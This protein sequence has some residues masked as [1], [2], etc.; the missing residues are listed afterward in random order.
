MNPIRLLVLS[1]LAIFASVALIGCGGGKTV[2]RVESEEVIDLSGDWND[3]D[4]QLVAKKMISDVLTRPWHTNFR[5]GEGRKPVVKVGSVVVRSMEVI[6][7]D[8]FTNDVVR[9]FINSGE[10]RAVR[11]RGSEWQTREEL[12][13][14]DK[15]ASS[16]SRKEAFKELGCDYLMTGSIKIQDD[17]DGNKAVKFYSVDLQLEDVMTGELVWLGN[18]K[19]KKFVER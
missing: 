14:Q 7:T 17:R 12:K 11:A 18:E 3:T 9:E 10:V 1:T 15:W 19:I 5:A 6:D 2:T 13:D 4:S 8:I 16:S